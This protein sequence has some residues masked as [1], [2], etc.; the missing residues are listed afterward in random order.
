MQVLARALHSALH[1]SFE[2]GFARIPYVWSFTQH[3]VMTLQ[4][5]K[6]IV[7]S[8]AMMPARLCSCTNIRNQL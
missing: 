2:I 3:G 8:E 6:I 4:V 5:S 7:L 1:P